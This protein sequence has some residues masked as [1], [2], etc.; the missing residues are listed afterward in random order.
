MKFYSLFDRKDSI[1]LR[2]MVNECVCVI[3]IACDGLDHVN[4][5]ASNANEIVY[6][7]LAEN[8]RMEKKNDLI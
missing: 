8:F 3:W 2:L 1:Y 5:V 7:A 6:F 4:A